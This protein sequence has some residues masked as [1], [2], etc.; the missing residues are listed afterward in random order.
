MA[1]QEDG[2]RPF[3]DVIVESSVTIEFDADFADDEQYEMPKI[4]LRLK[5]F[6]LCYW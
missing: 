6:P 3:E 1:E 5:A 4:A 2:A